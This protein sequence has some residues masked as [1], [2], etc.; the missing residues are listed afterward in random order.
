[1][2]YIITSTNPFVSIKLTEKGREQ[3]ALG[4]LNFSFWGIGDSEL[5]YDREAIVDAN[6]SD[7]TLSASSMIMRPFDRQ[8]NIKSYITPKGVSTPFQ[9]I[10]AANMN[11]IKAVVNNAALERGFFDHTGN[12]FTTFTATTFTP[13]Q[14]SVANTAIAGGNQLTISNATAISVGDYILIKLPNFVTGNLT[15]NDNTTPL[16][17]LWFK[18]QGITGNTLQVDRTLPN[19]ATVPNTSELIVYRGGEVWDTIA[20][21]NTTA[22]W[23]SG[24]LTFNSAV[25]ITCH[26]VPVWDMNNV[27]CESM[28]GMSGGT[29]FEDF[30]KFGSYKYLGTKNPYLEYLCESSGITDNVNCNGPGISYPDD[31]AKAIS[32]I[33]Y[34][35]NTI[36]SL[37][38][39]YFYVDATKN[40]IVKLHIPDL[41]YHKTAYVT[42]SGTTMGMTF[43][44]SGSTQLLGNS[45]I[46]Y[47][48]LIE[49]PSLLS[50]G[51]TLPV[52]VGRVF[53]QLKMIVIHDEEIVAAISYKSNRNWTLPPLA[54]TI[55]SP[56]GGTSTGVLPPNKTIYLTYS[57]EISG[58]TGLTTSL[59][60]QDYI[61]VTNTTSGAKDIGFRID[62][63]DHLPYMRKIESGGYDGLGFFATNFK[64]LYQIVNDPTERPDPGKWMKFDYTST[65]I[66]TVSGQTIDPVKLENQ[67]PTVNG[68]IL[69]LPTSS[70]ATNF[71][72][73]PLL[74]MAPNNQPTYLQFGD[75]RLFYGNVETYIGAT[76]YKTIF[77][78]RVNASTFTETS[79][80]TRSKDLSTNPPN[81][82]VTEVGVYDVDKNLVC[83]GKLSKPVA[84]IAGNT[85][86][87]ELSMDF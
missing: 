7:V 83:I 86:M 60:C 13:Y 44:A 41:M 24:T 22:Y 14:E 68:F 62:T 25:N 18:V 45:D 46:E 20:T 49:D 21:G 12:T 6:Q 31:V 34:T 77:D 76:I 37:Y 17:N 36:S 55:L 52:V 38:G 75:E 26:D 54:A 8:P 70:G 85:I 67:N 27:W 59:P 65:N 87:L 74:N 57:L 35:N 29:A 3:L 19:Y 78:V 71:D 1:M 84:L 82:K 42:G 10:T 5:N 47:I 23:D 39:E 66:T 11:V 40:K 69:D 64:L 30:T 63:A 33:H 48:D 2:S 50:S 28:A 16:P 32:I 15:L 80:P 79:N 51:Y 9:P 56:S 4:Q 53:P 72:L 73:I 43:L 61:K 58:T 81:I